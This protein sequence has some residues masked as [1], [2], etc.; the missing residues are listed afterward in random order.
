MTLD[1]KIVYYVQSVLKAFDALNH[2]FFS[3][4][5]SASQLSV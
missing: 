2:Y 1:K 3:Y 5:L 4:T